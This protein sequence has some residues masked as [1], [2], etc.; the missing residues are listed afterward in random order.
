[1]AGR[2][3][4]IPVLDRWIVH[5]PLHDV[6]ALV[7]QASVAELRQGASG[8][9]SKPLA[10]LAATLR[11]EPAAMPRPLAGDPVPSFLGI[12]PTRGCN[13]HCAYCG[14]GG[15]G[16]SKKQIDPAIAVA[17][18]DWMADQMVRAGRDTLRIH[19]F[20]GE[21]FLAGDVV[22][23]VVHRARYVAAR[24]RLIPRFDASTNGVFN[25]ARCQFVGD[26]FDSI[27]L[28]LDGFR[29]DHDRNRPAAPG[30]GSFDLVERTA[31]RLAAMPLHLCL[32]AC[33]TAES[34]G[35]MEE[36][37]RW[38]IEAFHPAI[39]N[40][41]TLTPC[42]EADRAGLRPPDPYEFAAHCVR[43]LQLAEALGVRATY[44]AAD[45]ETPRLTFCPVGTDA[46]IVSVD[47]TVS[48]CY[49]LPEEWQRQ[50]LELTVGRAT[51][52]AGLVLESDAIAR[53][54]RHVADKPARC[55]RCLGLWSCAGGCHVNH[56]PPRCAD[57]YD[58][59]CVQTRIITAC[60]LL[61]GMG[62]E[63]LID[64]LLA[65]R[66]ALENLAFHPDDGLLVGEV[67]CGCD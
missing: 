20:G 67:P 28:S 8:A 62:C 21:P 1:M 43:S 65:S 3:F 66:S 47:G 36:T 42:P 44:S 29:E 27:V 58:D 24:K 37:T 54:R 48:A 7:N 53:V 49:L 31:R 22:E 23:I 12:I 61:R 9:R 15:P 34:V 57:Q 30:R 52:D 11:A 4:A 35:R 32:R 46:M 17:A 56:S 19:F 63:D 55:R 16:A 10:E 64:P 40:F 38:M 41:E 50:G 51:R 18:V 6:T 45:L 33:I 25:E 60:Q 39:I 13:L 26:Y 5:A 14:F 59:F 2:V